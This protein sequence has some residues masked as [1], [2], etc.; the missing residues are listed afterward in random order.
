MKGISAADFAGIARRRLLLIYMLFLIFPGMNVSAWA[1][2][3]YEPPDGRVIH[4]IG[5]YVSYFYTDAENWQLVQEYQ[6][7]INKIPMVYSVYAYLDPTIN[8]I[9]Q[10]DFIDITTNHGYPYVL[11]VGLGLFDIS[12]ILTGNIN[13]PVQTILSGN[14]DGQI[15]NLAQRIKAVN[16]PVYLRPGFEFG[17]GNSG[18]H[19]DPDVGPTDFIN[20]WMHIYNIFQQEN[21]TNV[22]WVWNTVNPQSFN[23][24]AWYP[25][26]SYV[27]WWGIN[28]FTASQI[29]A[30]DG[31]L[32]NAAQHNKP[33][34][35]CES[36]PIQNGGT[37]NSSNWN[38]WFIPYFQKIQNNQNIKAFI[39]IS[40]PWDKSGFF[41][42]W[43]DSR[44]TSNST[45]Q[46]NYSQE[47]TDSVY[48]HMDEYLANPGIIGLAP[49]AGSLVIS[50]F[51]ANP[52]AVSDNDGEYVEF[53][54]NTADTIDIDGFILKDDDTDS[55]VINNGGP[56][57]IPANGFLVMGNNGD[58]LMNG[59]Y[60][61][62]YVYS[63]FALA[64]A[65]DEI[66]LQA[67]GGTEICRL[68]YA[69]GNPF[70]GGVS[71]ELSNVALHVNGVTQ[72]SDYVAA[73]DTLPAGDLGSPGSAGN[74][75]GAGGG[76]PAPAIGNVIRSPRIPNANQ[77]TTIIADIADAS[78]GRALLLVEL[79]YVI[80]DGTM[81]SVAMT[82]TGGN[83]YSA[84]IPAS[85]Y[86]DGDRVEYWIYA[87]DDL[88]QSS[89]SAHFDYFAGDTPISNIHP[90]DMNGALLYN[91]YDVRVTGVATAETGIYSTTNIDAYIQDSSGGVNIFQF[92]LPVSMTRENSYTVTGIL[93]QFNGKAEVVPD[94]PVNDIVDNG[95]ATLLNAL[96]KTIAELLLDPEA[97]EGMLIKILQ[98][99][100]TGGAD[101]WPPSGSNANIEITDD[102][103][104]SLLTLRIDQDTDIDGSP[105]P[106]WPVDIQ[107]IF[108]QFDNSSPYTEGYQIMPRDTADIGAACTPGFLGDINGDGIAN[109]TDALIAL[110]FDAGLPIPQPILDRINLGFGDVN[111]DGVTNSTDALLLLSFDAQI[112][113]PFPVG[114]PVCL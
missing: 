38:N 108:A 27:D 83:T 47:M 37:T 85:D 98:V 66:V 63:S 103:G 39:Y 17:S 73:S 55:I 11:V 86:G 95:P 44:I 5:Q 12:Y 8:L 113:V 21:V 1:G 49:P 62:D 77:N 64:N 50:E 79:R 53:Y 54:N 19:N 61:N 29:N 65:S 20:I 40:D 26:D 41:D 96:E 24:M 80:N 105:E 59:G 52:A 31:F 75:Q 51:M 74:T 15:Q 89:E 67:P 104:N 78:V 25:G 71:L 32:N 82:N 9:D 100:T 76:N 4:G 18:I 94:D 90:V 34:M 81:Q 56:L 7:A 102:G 93:D 16:A 101:P 28:Y 92:G 110:S 88:V 43:P 114:D 30:G 99:D 57:L 3:K 33:V 91:G 45:I 6:N 111:T 87:E 48:I 109:S 10:T 14:W 22:A 97:Y 84:D 106:N 42:S 70:G 36:N 107:G 69:N 35:I 13:I 112:F 58:S 2:T 68:V 46:A 60:H 23:Y 72:E